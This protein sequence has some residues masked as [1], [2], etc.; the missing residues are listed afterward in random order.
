MNKNIAISIFLVAILVFSYLIISKEDT[1]KEEVKTSSLPV[2]EKIDGNAKVKTVQSK[3]E[4]KKIIPKKRLKKETKKNKTKPVLVNL[5]TDVEFFLYQAKNDDLHNILREDIDKIISKLQDIGE[6]H[7]VEYEAILNLYKSNISNDRKIFLASILGEIGTYESASTLTKILDLD[8]DSSSLIYE[9]TR[10][11]K[12]LIYNDKTGKINSDVSSALMEYWKNSD[13][14][15]YKPIVATAILKIGNLKESKKI[16]NMLNEPTDNDEV[17]YI[18]NAMKKIRNEKTTAYLYKKYNSEDSS[19][20]LKNAS[21][22][23]LPYIANKTATLSLYDWSSKTSDIDKVKQ[24][25]EIIKQRNPNAE[26]I[27]KEELFANKSE[28]EF[29]KVK[30][31]IERIFKKEIK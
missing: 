18:S 9:N 19:E 21:I 17:D 15:T 4:D 16:I 22:E 31:A 1:T 29:P 27:V 11:I 8:N 23:A 24:Y 10:A 5:D 26:M 6:N 12:N 3:I 30:V 13:N 20:V 2:K 14:T 7:Q 28:F 25:F